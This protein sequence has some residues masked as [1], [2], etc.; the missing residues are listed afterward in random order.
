MDWTQLGQ[1]WATKPLPFTK[2]I[3]KSE[4]KM[5]VVDDNSKPGTQ[6]HNNFT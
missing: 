2:L 5:S 1:A 4:G 6:M 3:E